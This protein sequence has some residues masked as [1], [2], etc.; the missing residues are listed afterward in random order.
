MPRGSAPCSLTLAFGRGLA[1]PITF[2]VVKGTAVPYLGLVEARSYRDR[3][4]RV[5]LAG[6]QGYVITL[7]QAV[8][9]SR[10]VVKEANFQQLLGTRLVRVRR[11]G[12]P[13]KGTLRRLSLPLLFGV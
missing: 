11:L 10:K 8:S 1:L 12:N 13:P 2:L 5:I 9:L 6:S 7:Q 4:K 3:M